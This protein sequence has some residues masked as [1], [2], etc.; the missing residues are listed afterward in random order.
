[1]ATTSHQRK[2]LPARQPW[3]LTMAG[4]GVVAVLAACGS[5]V[6]G[7]NAGSTTSPSQAPSTPPAV[8]PSDACA[9]V[10]TLR[11]A[12][13]N[14]GKISVTANNGAQISAD[15]TKIETAL[16]AL[17]DEIGPAFS[18]EAHQL[19]APLTAISK[20][21]QALA[22][23]PTQANLQATTTSVRELKTA[24]GPAIA[25]MRAACPSS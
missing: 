12:L 4:L 19:S 6:T 14:L 25:I 15:L 23:H 2:L 5:G 8:T 3:L 13:T 16:T 18:A 21:A 24:A 20:H 10:T 17:K 9:Q 1:M 11:A 7:T 22:A